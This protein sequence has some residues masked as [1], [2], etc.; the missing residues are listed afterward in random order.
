L[1]MVGCL[2]GKTMLNM[3][4]TGK[5]AVNGKRRANEACESLVV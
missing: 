4:L 3:I 1:G 5:E 2:Q